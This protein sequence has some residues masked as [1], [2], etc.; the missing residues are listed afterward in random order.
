MR[1]KKLFALVLAFFAVFAVATAGTSA[2][3]AN[4]TADVVSEADVVRAAEN[5]PPTN[6]WMLYTRAGTPATAAQFVTGPASPPAG[7]GSLRLTTAT[8]SEKVFLF[9]YDHIGKDLGDVTEIKYSTYRTSGSGSQVAALN[10]QVDFNGPDVAGGFTTLVFEPVYNTSQGVVTNN[11][12]QTWDAFAGRWWSTQPINGQ[13]AGAVTACIRTWSQIV[14]NNPDAVIIGGFGINQGSGNAGLVT[15]VDRLVIGFSTAACPFVYDFELD[16]DGD[17][18]GDSADNCPA[19]PNPDQ[20]DLDGDGAGDACDSD[21][22]GDGIDDTLD[23]C[24]AVSNADQAD[25]DGDGIGNAC[26]SDNDNDGV[27]DAVDNCPATPNS[28]QAD[29]DGDGMGDACDSDDDN[30]GVNDAVDNCPTTPN[31]NQADFDGDGIGD[32]CDSPSGPPTTK[33]Q[34]KNGGWMNWS[35]RFKNQGDCI[36]YFNTGK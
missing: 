4:C 3:Q 10:V 7:A 9:N 12:W 20:A 6:D 28:D 25:S 23:N 11:T 5:T 34:C 30:D 22:D 15:F 24:P 35:P 1:A 19:T 17:G 8:G 27:D 21:D 2:R 31:A 16:T 18:V 36:Q 13:C 32:A 33:D 26:D 14:A 29:L